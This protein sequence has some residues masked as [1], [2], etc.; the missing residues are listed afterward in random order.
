MTYSKTISIAL[1]STVVACSASAPREE[2]QPDPDQL[3]NLGADGCPAGLSEGGMG[4]DMVR[5][6]EG[7]CMDTTE[8]KR[9]EY[10]E[11][12]ETAPS[13]SGQSAS[14]SENDD[15]ASTCGDDRFPDN[16]AVC[17]DWC[18]AKAFCEA[19]GKRLCGQIGTGEGYAFDSYDDPAVSEWHAACT[20]GGQYEYTHGNEPVLVEETGDANPGC[21]DADTGH[22]STYGFSDVGSFSECHSP[23]A[24]YAAVYDLSGHAAEWDNS[25]DG[26]DPDAPCR[27]RGGSFEHHGRGLRCAM[28]RGLRWPRSRRAVSVGFRCCAD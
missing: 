6:P 2:L 26:D 13:T 8:V 4:P 9:G 5:L 20:S 23:D 3:H 11:W 7:F 22:Y 15:F 27:I 25:C 19:A 16:P 12:V 14:C 18:D 1:F 21:R 17:V 24:D 10:N 28:A